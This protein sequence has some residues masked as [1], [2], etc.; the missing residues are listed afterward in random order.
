MTDGA[1]AAPGI[2]VRPAEAPGVSAGVGGGGAGYATW[3]VTTVDAP[4][5]CTMLDPPCAAVARA[6]RYDGTVADVAVVVLALS[7]RLACVQQEVTR[8]GQPHAW[9]AWVDRDDIRLLPVRLTPRGVAGRVVRVPP[10][11]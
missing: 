8:D 7:G 4:R 2:P 5:E 9:N 6:A 10:P 3:I 11:A 1:P